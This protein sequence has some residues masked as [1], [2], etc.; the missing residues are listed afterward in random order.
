MR[1]HAAVRLPAST[2][3]GSR[4]PDVQAEPLDAQI[5][6]HIQHNQHGLSLHKLEAYVDIVWQDDCFGVRLIF[7]YGIS[8]VKHG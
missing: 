1:S 6:M 3:E 5:P 7:T 8:L 2:W 4:E